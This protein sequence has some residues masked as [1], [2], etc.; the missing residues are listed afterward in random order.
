M[1][2]KPSTDQLYGKGKKN[3]YTCQLGHTTVTID[4]D[5][6]VTP[7]M[8]KCRHEKCQE[9]A[10]S[11]FYRCDQSLEP[12]H[13]WYRPKTS[14]L[15]NLDGNTLRHVQQGGL[16]LR[17][18]GGSGLEEAELHHDLALQREVKKLEARLDRVGVREVVI[19]YEL[20]PLG[21]GRIVMMMPAD[22][23][24]T[25]IDSAVRALGMYMSRRGYVPEQAANAELS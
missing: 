9:I 7:F 13:E 15:P 1:E 8:T 17:K 23:S 22:A 19:H 10:H 3:C 4:R 24:R 25:E 20:P 16:L 12:T 2:K 6:G 18:I 5:K 11:S 14:A 21:A